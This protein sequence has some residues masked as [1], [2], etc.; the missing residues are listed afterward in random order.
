MSVPSSP[1]L[2]LDGTPAEASELPE[3]PPVAK[4]DLSQV[5]ERALARELKRRRVCRVCGYENSSGWFLDTSKPYPICAD[6][7][8][9]SLGINPHVRGKLA[10]ELVKEYYQKLSAGGL[11][12]HGSST[13][14]EVE[15]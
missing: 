8:C 9:R 4:V 15:P 7:K 14:I 13:S 10:V 6:C 1:Q 11:E 2:T 5:D 12:T 3:A